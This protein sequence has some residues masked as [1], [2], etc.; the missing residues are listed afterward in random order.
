MNT[1]IFDAVRTPRG[2]GKAS[3]GGLTSVSPVELAAI[4]LKALQ[5]RNHLDSRHVN[6]VV[7]GCVE[8]VMDQAAD[9][10][11]SAVLLAGYDYCVPGQ[12]INRFCAS[13]LDA[14]ATIAAKVASGQIEL[15]IGGGIEMM[16]R[17]QMGASGYPPLTDPVLA[18]PNKMIPQ[19]V[20]ADLL[21]TLSG[22]SREDV[23]AYA[24]TS[25]S[26]AVAAW[27]AGRF[28]RGIVPVKDSNGLTV[29]A[30]DELLRPDVSLA[31][32]GKMEPSFALMAIMGGF[33][34]V[35]IQRYPQIEVLQYLHH[36]GNSSGISDGAAAVLIGSENAGRKNSLKPRAR[37][38]SFA[39]IGSEPT[40]M[41]TGPDA[42]CRKALSMARMNH[43]DIDLWEVNEAF[44]SV[45][46]RFM[47]DS[48]VD[49][50]R[51]NVNGGAIAMGHP[52]GATGAML[53]G[54]LIDELELSDRNTGVV[55]LC[56][57]SG[58]AVAMVVERV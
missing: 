9:I 1:Y 54:T 3:S 49:L 35:A 14:C 18:I 43:K 15:G 16:S 10:A 22:Y 4:P 6:D 50:N 11:R 33:D 12:Q 42:A 23:D 27:Q 55:T 34:A 44:S 37:I 45:V 40:V 56:A 2:K 20:S 52:L 28:E 31:S 51:V 39:S 36:P 47:D 7:L 25:Q 8:P 46:L 24:V 57:A 32:L 48:D 5:E 30:Q 17:L 41:L 58:M 13:G 19:G 29:L 53:L 38:I 21:G 26:R